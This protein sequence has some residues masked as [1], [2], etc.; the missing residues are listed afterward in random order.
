MQ[1]L[2]S[3]SQYLGPG[4][5]ELVQV[6]VNY[7][8]CPQDREGEMG[9]AASF[10]GTVFHWDLILLLIS[11]GD[12]GPLSEWKFACS[13]WLCPSLQEP[14]PIQARQDFSRDSSWF[15]ALKNGLL[16]GRWWWGTQS[17]LQRPKGSWAANTPCLFPVFF[18]T[19]QVELHEDLTCSKSSDPGI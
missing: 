3:K 15:K 10:W 12:N 16:L 2:L 5:V 9:C 17:P 1:Q 8:T 19:K 18:T 14:P 4:T 13:F 7:P 11:W 6:G